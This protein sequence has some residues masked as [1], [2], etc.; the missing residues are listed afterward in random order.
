MDQPEERRD[1][2]RRR[3]LRFRLAILLVGLPLA[4][5][6]SA[7]VAGRVLQSKWGMYRDPLTV[8]PQRFMRDYDHYLELRDPA[9]GWPFPS[10]FGGSYTT[11]GA[12]P[13]PANAALP[14][15]PHVSL[16]GDSF[17]WGLTNQTPEESWAN[18]LATKLGERVM[19][20]GVGGYGSDQ[21]CLRYL[22]QVDDDAEAVVLGHMSENMTRN[23]TRLRDFTGGGGQAFSFKPRF[24]LDADGRLEQVPLPD[25]TE[26]EYLRYLGVRDP[27]LVLPHEHFHPGGPMGAVRLTF[28][29]SMAVLRNLGYWRLQA[30][31]AGEPEYARFYDPQH[32]AGGLQL[33]AAILTRFVEV[34]RERGQRP[35]VVLFPGC[36]D[37]TQRQQTGVSLLAGLATRVRACGVVVVDFTELL[38]DYLGDR[39]A[40][41][42]YANHHFTHEVDPL[43]ADAVAQALLAE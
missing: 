31:L 19:N 28:P 27:Q 5:E 41:A 13:V 6:L 34:A 26:D 9:L 36:E 22:R 40:E 21:A 4:A 14:E 29:F 11:A 7:Y 32:F 35:L 42:I 1:R 20:F 38:A 25:L 12:V 2:R 8:R 18:L 33:T 30:R 37:L 17:T 23:L 3:R 43:V 16:Y 24:V 10:E 15:S 39:P